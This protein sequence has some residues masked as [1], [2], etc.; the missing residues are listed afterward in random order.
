MSMKEAF[1]N[2]FTKLESSCKNKNVC[3]PKTV[4]VEKCDFHG[5][6]IKGSIDHEG[7]AEWKPILQN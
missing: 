6:Y 4:Y 5:I 7:Y 1:E 3:M 2:Y